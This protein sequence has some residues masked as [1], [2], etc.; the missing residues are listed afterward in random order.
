MNKPLGE[1]TRDEI[2]PF[3]KNYKKGYYN[4]GD[5]S[6]EP[7][8]G[9]EE[10]S[11]YCLAAHYGFL[12][13]MID[14]ENNL[15]TKWYLNRKDNQGKDAYIHAAI[16]NQIEIMK[17]LEKLHRKNR[18]KKLETRETWSSDMI[19][20]NGLNAFSY[21]LLKNNNE[22]CRHIFNRFKKINDRKMQYNKHIFPMY[23]HFFAMDISQN[24]KIR[25][26]NYF[27][28]NSLEML[29]MLEDI[30]K[31]NLK[32]NEK[33]R[34]YEYTD[35]R[36]FVKLLEFSIYSI[37][38]IY[39]RVSGR[40]LYL[41]EIHYGNLGSAELLLKKYPEFG[42]SYQSENLVY[43]RF[44]VEANKA[45]IDE[46]GP[47]IEKKIAENPD[48]SDN[49][50]Y[51]IYLHKYNLQNDETPD[52]I[53]E[54]L[55]IIDFLEKH[56]PLSETNKMDLAKNNLL[57]FYSNKYL[58]RNKIDD[59][60]EELV[61]ITKIRFDNNKNLLMIA[62]EY[63]LKRKIKY[64]LGKYKWNLYHKDS[65]NRDIIGYC[66]SR[67][68]LRYLFFKM[69]STFKNAKVHTGFSEIC[70]ICKS[71]FKSDDPICKCFN[72][73][74]TC[75]PC[76][77]DYLEVNG[78]VKSDELKCALCSEKMLN[79]C[80]TY[81]QLKALYDYENAKMLKTAQIDTDDVSIEC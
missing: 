5:F 71:D 50:I 48:S 3:L 19:D 51:N 52:E 81:G 56:Y 67:N 10:C 2:N 41:Q 80:Q 18:K 24:K 21:G 33:R 8:F 36:V 49:V 44:Y 60:I 43:D 28:T 46:I 77:L 6:S 16:G 70:I 69:T 61:D 62:V 38:S 25:I 37:S 30:H 27:A 57:T 63:D 79:S 31:Y 72:G 76:Y 34:K 65:K 78:I 54:K 40:N 17:H 4:I 14:L 11:L 68:I 35:R 9:E 15:N 64:L 58:R 66:K 53:D 23:N 13:I 22:V 7:T 1:I 26:N 59:H 55:R 42:E 39:N 47:L 29:E 75:Q 20:N 32:I 12:D 45:N 74:M 73:H